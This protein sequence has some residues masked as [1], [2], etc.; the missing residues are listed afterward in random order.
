KGIHESEQGQKASKA[1]PPIVSS[2]IA[3]WRPIVQTFGI[4]GMTNA[5]YYL[6]FTFAVEQRKETIGADGASFQ[7]VNTLSLF[8]VLFAKVLGG[9]LSDRVGRRKMML[10]LTIATMGAVYFA[11]PIMMAGSPMEFML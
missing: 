11:L 2:L 4:V 8:V 7:L 9:W 6:V 10:S 1:R 3:D 5:A